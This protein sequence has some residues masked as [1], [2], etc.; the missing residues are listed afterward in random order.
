MPLSEQEQ[1]LLEEM[2]RS[3]Y[4]NDADL[5]AGAGGRHGRPTYGRIAAGVLVGVVG[6]ATLVA[7]VGIRIPV[8]GVVGFV[9]MF[10]GVL[11]AL[12][13]SRGGRA[14]RPAA[15][16]TGSAASGSKAGSSGPGT[17]EPG[18]GERWESRTDEQD[19]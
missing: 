14:A 19:E 15:A 3:L 4:H 11:L 13:P 7:G 6:I 18:S 1:R 8:V 2:E 10:L 12:T 17:S 9:L 16:A 5:V